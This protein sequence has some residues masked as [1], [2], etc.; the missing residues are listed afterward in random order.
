M[1]SAII[2]STILA[3]VAVTAQMTGD[4]GRRMMYGGGG[5]NFAGVMTWIFFVGLT[6]LVWLWVFKLWRE[7][8][9]RK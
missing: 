7:M 1:K 5:T 9:K 8:R 6:L 3:S 2:L 4:I